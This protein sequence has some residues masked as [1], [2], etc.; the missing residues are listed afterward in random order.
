MKSKLMR[1]CCKGGYLQQGG[2]LEAKYTQV[3]SAAG[4][5]LGTALTALG[6]PGLG[7]IFSALGS[8]IGKKIGE[9]KDLQNRLNELTV[10]KNPYGFA[11]GGALSGMEDAAV[12]KGRLHNKGGIMVNAKGVPSN[13]PDAEVEGGEVKVTLGGKEYIFSNR[14]I[15]K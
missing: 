8:V 6:V 13:K 4:S 15:I 14:L 1:K 3:G 5:V 9:P 12:Y 11:L 2:P 10:N 7:G